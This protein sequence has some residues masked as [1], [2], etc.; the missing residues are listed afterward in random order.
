MV[1]Q[2]LDNLINALLFLKEM[3]YNL[4]LSPSFMSHKRYEGEKEKH[5]N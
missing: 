5:D 2:V 1:G 4:E 3:D